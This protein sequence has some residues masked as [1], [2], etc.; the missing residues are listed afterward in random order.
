MGRTGIVGELRRPERLSYATNMRRLALNLFLPVLAVSGTNL[1]R[2]QQVETTTPA[3]RLAL[4]ST[5]ETTEPSPRVA[6]LQLPP[7]L[8]AAGREFEKLERE[9]TNVREVLERVRS[10]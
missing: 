2:A 1:L 5:C 9:Y 10:A 3:P 6:G 4:L 7:D 8:E